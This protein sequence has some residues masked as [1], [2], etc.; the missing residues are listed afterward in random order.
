M[1]RGIKGGPWPHIIWVSTAGYYVGKY[2]HMSL[3]Q[4][5]GEELMSIPNSLLG[6]AI[7]IEKERKKKGK[8][9]SSEEVELRNEWLKETL[10][11]PCLP[12]GTGCGLLAY[13]YVKSGAFDFY[14]LLIKR[15]TF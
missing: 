2:S 9:P 1:K 10:Q 13:L 14:I 5:M 7:R 4:K 3:S 12:L 11:K 6:E 8:K 15:T